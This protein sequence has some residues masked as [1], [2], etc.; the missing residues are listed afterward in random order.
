MQELG[1]DI[2]RTAVREV[3]EET[4]LDMEITGLVGICIAPGHVL[5]TSAS[6]SQHRGPEPLGVGEPPG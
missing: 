1:E 5:V 4:G 6:A 3:R 2:T